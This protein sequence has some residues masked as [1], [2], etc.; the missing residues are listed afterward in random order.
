M[1][2]LH[3]L[4]TDI[5]DLDIELLKNV[6]YAHGCANSQ[7]KHQ[8]YKAFG[9]YPQAY[10]VTEKQISEAT[11]LYEIKKQ[12]LI[13]ELKQTENVLLMVGMGMEYE[14]PL[15]N[16]VNNHRIR[17]YFI[18]NNGT[19]CFIEFGKGYSKGTEHKLRIDHAI[20]NAD[21]TQ[22]TINNYGNLERNT[23]NLDYTYLDYTY[24]NIL[25]IVNQ[26]FDCS[27]TSVHYDYFLLTTEDYTSKSKKVQK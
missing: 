14:N 2:I 10:K 25:K 8:Y 15:K 6:T 23:P 16:G 9:H 27:F 18:N 11:K 19:K 22:E 24:E 21:V 26:N 7:G 4:K 17:G 3:E 13:Q 20:L 5:K 12:Q 1:E